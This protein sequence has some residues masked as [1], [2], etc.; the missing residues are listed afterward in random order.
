MPSAR[1]PI[2]LYVEGVLLADASSAVARQV[3]FL[4]SF[5]CGNL[6]AKILIFTEKPLGQADGLRLG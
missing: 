5:L 1:A 3:R 2:A 4:L 6:K